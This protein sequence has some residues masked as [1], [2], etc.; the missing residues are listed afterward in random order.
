MIELSLAA[1]RAVASKRPS[2]YLED[3]LAAASAV[4]NDVVLIEP[5]AYRDLVSRYR[6]RPGLGDIVAT[7]LSRIGITKSRAQRVAAA[8]GIA[9]CGCSRRRAAL[10]ALGKRFGIGGK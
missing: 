10:N 8:F 2:G 6:A 1:V 5:D 3:V 4:Q 7:G 9:D